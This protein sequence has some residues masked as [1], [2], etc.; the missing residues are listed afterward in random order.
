VPGRQF[1][2]ATTRTP[3]LQKVC[4]KH[5]TNTLPHPHITMSA[6]Q[7][8]PLS[9]TPFSSYPIHPSYIE[10]NI[11]A[12]TDRCINTALHLNQMKLTGRQA[13]TH[14]ESDCMHM[15]AL[16]WHTHMH[17][18]MSVIPSCKPCQP[19]CTVRKQRL[20]STHHIHSSNQQEPC[21]LSRNPVRLTEPPLALIFKLRPYKALD[22]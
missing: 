12:S 1:L 15:Q 16:S 9:I 8:T 10:A 19:P 7:Y 22:L 14:K 18:T 20:K 4:L 13:H 3:V 6:A 5:S 17:T 2:G 11:L 21:R